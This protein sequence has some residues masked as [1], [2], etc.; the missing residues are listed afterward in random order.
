MA[1]TFSH[2]CCRRAAEG[3]PEVRP[4]AAEYRSQQIGSPAVQTQSK[5]QTQTI[6]RALGPTCA[7]NRITHRSHHGTKRHSSRLHA[8][9]NMLGSCRGLPK[10][11]KRPMPYTSVRPHLHRSRYLTCERSHTSIMAAHLSI[12]ANTWWVASLP[13][14]LCSSPSAP[15]FAAGRIS[16]RSRRCPRCSQG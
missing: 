10:R 6:T 2:H 3:S 13:Q 1:G 5:P 14:A 4:G 9:V 7:K 12:N 16:H 8:L 15:L 11:Q